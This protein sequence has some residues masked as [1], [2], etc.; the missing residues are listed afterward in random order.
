[1]NDAL[2]LI[3]EEVNC[4]LIRKSQSYALT[5]LLQLVTTDLRNA[6][7]FVTEDA[8][9]A[10]KTDTVEEAF[11]SQNLSLKTERSTNAS[12]RK[13]LSQLDAKRLQR[14][15]RGLQA[16]MNAKGYPAVVCWEPSRR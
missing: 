5:M 8:L 14:C 2:V 16:H 9:A 12:Q 13:H 1:M 4:D 11:S 3:E 15:G 10:A 7:V 6:E